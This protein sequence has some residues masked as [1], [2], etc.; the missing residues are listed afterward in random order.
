MHPV[1]TIFPRTP[2]N[3]CSRRLIQRFLECLSTPSSTSSNWACHKRDFLDDTH[4]WPSPS[5]SIASD[6]IIRRIRH[7]PSR[8]TSDACLQST[9]SMLLNELGLWGDLLRDQ[10]AQDN[11]PFDIHLPFTKRSYERHPFVSIIAMMCTGGKGVIK[12]S[13]RWHEFLLY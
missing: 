11:I 13:G 4:F 8:T 7:G 10:T 2:T 5:A 6:A 12:Q 9:W 3:W 1:P